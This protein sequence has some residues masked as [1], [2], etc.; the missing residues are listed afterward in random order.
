M[1]AER[2]GRRLRRVGFAPRIAFAVDTRTL[3][4]PASRSRFPMTSMVWTLDSCGRRTLPLILSV[5]GST[6]AADA[7]AA[8]LGVGVRRAVATSSGSS[9]IGRSRTCSGASQSGKFPRVVLDE[10]ADETFV[11]AE[12]GAMDAERSLFRVVAVFVNQ[13]EALEARRSRPDWSRW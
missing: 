11:R 1:E 10:E 6:S 13:A 4:A 9:P 8:E 12:R 2:I 3:T 5:D 7:V